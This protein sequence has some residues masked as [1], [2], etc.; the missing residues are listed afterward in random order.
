MSQSSQKDKLLFRL[1]EEL[2]EDLNKLNDYVQILYEH[3]TAGVN[4]AHL[5]NLLEISADVTRLYR[6][7][8]SLLDIQKIDSGTLTLSRNQHSIREIITDTITPINHLAQ[9]K[10]V[11]IR[12]ELE[13]VICSCDKNKI[14]QVIF[15]LLIN[16]IDFCPKENGLIVIQ[17]SRENENAKIVIKDNGLGVT[18]ENLQKLFDSNYQIQISVER[19]HVESGLALPVCKTVID[20]HG[21]KIWTASQGRDWG[22]EIHILLP[23]KS[24]DDVMVKKLD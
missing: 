18:K 19:E 17:L 21:G 2:G 8:N 3:H 11:T 1:T 20:L 12:P 5:D 9:R 7:Q 4:Q 14:E 6:I 22:T 13:D 10:K 15:N 24:E 16:A 23:L